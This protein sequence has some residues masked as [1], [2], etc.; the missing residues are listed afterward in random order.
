MT[1]PIPVPAYASQSSVTERVSYDELVGVGGTETVVNESVFER[2]P[3]PYELRASTTSEY[4]WL[5]SSS[6]ATESPV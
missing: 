1:A 6:D 2:Q 5:G 3:K 4:G